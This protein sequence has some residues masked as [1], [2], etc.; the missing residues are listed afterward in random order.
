MRITPENNY[1]TKNNNSQNELNKKYYQLMADLQTIEAAI[2][3]M[4][5]RAVATDQSADESPA[6]QKPFIDELNTLMTIKDS[7]NAYLNTLKNCSVLGFT[8]NKV[9]DVDLS[10]LSN[11][12]DVIHELPVYKNHHD[13]KQGPRQP[14]KSAS[15]LLQGA[16]KMDYNPSTKKIWAR[17]AGF[18]LTCAACT[19]I[20]ITGIALLMTPGIN[21]LAAIVAVP[22]TIKAS[23]AFFGLCAPAAIKTGINLGFGTAK[24]STPMPSTIGSSAGG[25]FG[26]FSLARKFSILN[27]E[28]E[29]AARTTQTAAI[30][31]LVNRLEEKINSDKDISVNV[32]DFLSNVIKKADTLY[33]EGASSSIAERRLSKTQK[34][35]RVLSA[36][37]ELIERF[38]PSKLSINQA[39][40]KVFDA[41]DNLTLK[42]F[43]YPEKKR[44]ADYLLKR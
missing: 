1:I 19:A 2:I 32:K 7:A 14:S 8:T 12:T 9:S 21:I 39:E 20:A 22:L 37:T 4:R 44:M 6:D 36:A 35:H 18:L 27:K 16:M 38:G 41:K 5:G 11:L 30:H 29:I 24:I 28:K 25:I 40:D 17:R 26:G 31:Q 33:D 13:N 3:T 43:L 34:A 15:E 10:V 23:A 42:S